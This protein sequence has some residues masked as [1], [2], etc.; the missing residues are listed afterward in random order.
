MSCECEMFWL[1]RFSDLY[2]VDSMLGV[3]FMPTLSLA[4]A[5]SLYGWM[6]TFTGPWRSGAYLNVLGNWEG[7]TACA[8]SEDDLPRISV[9][10]QRMLH[11]PNPA[12]SAPR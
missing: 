8:G 5:E 10:A 11:F 12:S 6:R 1:D 7:E 2:H 3:G 9:A 4:D